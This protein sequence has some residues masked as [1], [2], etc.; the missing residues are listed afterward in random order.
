MPNEEYGRRL[1]IAAYGIAARGGGSVASAGSLILDQLL[2]RGHRVDFYTARGYVDPA[3][4]NSHERYRYFPILAPRTA[5]GWKAIERMPEVVR[6][7]AALLYSQY[8]VA[9]HDRAIARAIAEGH[10]RQ[11]YDVFLMLGHLA[12]FR[13][14]GLPGVSWPQGPP[15]SEWRTLRSLR[16]PLEPY[17][18]SGLYAALAILYRFKHRVSRRQVGFSD[19][20]ICGSLWAAGEWADFGVAPGS[21]RPI[22][23]PIDLEM[24]RPAPSEGV[25]AGE[26]PGRF[27]WLGRIVPRKRLD[28]AL[29]AFRLLKAARPEASLTI[30]GD[31]P[32]AKGLRRLLSDH[33][34]VEGI[35]Y[36]SSLARS[37]VP[38]LLRR[39]DAIIQ[40]S[41][42]E[43]L[44]SAVL[45]GL[46]AGLPAIVGPTNG[47]KDYLG[48]SSIV[49]D[50]YTPEAIA[51]AMAQM[52][53]RIRSQGREAIASDCRSAAERHLAA[54]PIV[55]AVEATIREASACPPLHQGPPDR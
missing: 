8:S 1:A 53:D 27:L 3:E 44:G 15:L 9:C 26:V 24:F 22:P 41:E 52:I 46:A 28:L 34:D 21:V 7:P 50:A 35:D 14:A 29:A 33:A 55:D 31:F 11:S 48:D 4:L 12:P 2:C 47:T 37:E 5:A 30:L 38:R 17:L 40:P 25:A 45:E 43:N 49:F 23:Y 13:I 18:G 10:A 32:Y 6:P 16:G 20:I 54:G 36:R 51:S 42:S 39:A 19:R